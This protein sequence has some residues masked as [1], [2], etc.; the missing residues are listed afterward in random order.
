MGEEICI[1][2]KGLKFIAL[3]ATREKYSLKEFNFLNFVIMKIKYFLFILF[4]YFKYYLIFKLIFLFFYNE[5]N[6]Y[7]IKSKIA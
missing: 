1:L 2:I 6:I 5:E 3:K 4:Y 7:L